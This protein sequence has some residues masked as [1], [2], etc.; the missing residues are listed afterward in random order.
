[1][2]VQQA[3][4]QLTT[5]LNILYD[6]REAKNIAAM[7][8]EAVT[9]WTRIERMLQ[10]H[11]VL[12]AQQVGVFE[13]YTEQL[14]RHRPVQYVLG[15]AW[16]Y[17]M[18]FFVNEHVLI[19]RPETEELVEWAVQ[20]AKSSGN[21]NKEP[22]VLDMGTGS[23]CIAIAMKKAL[24]GARVV[25]C[26]VSEDALQVASR[27][28]S[29]NNVQIMLQHCNFLLPAQRG[30]LPHTDVL[31]SNPPYIPY[32][33]SA[34]MQPGVLGYEPY[35]ALFVPDEDA[36]LFYIALADFAQTYLQPGGAVY[37]EIHERMA[38]RIKELFAGYGYK[39]IELRQD[40][41]GKDRMVKL[42]KDE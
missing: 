2:T 9:G 28:A 41:Q 19:P 8:M 13:D 21:A 12:G 24:P 3:T 40:L 23:G 30:L 29:F 39:R 5:Q 31:I 25:A 42:I 27:N 4:Q 16:F 15:E 38:D 1:M 37:L 14:L 6:S 7:V 11:H 36:L 10:K 20:D 34:D 35:N 17:G 22:A 18:K 33:D 32:N 26:D